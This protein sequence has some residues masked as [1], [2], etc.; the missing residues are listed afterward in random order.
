MSRWS[1][2]IFW[3]LL[4]AA[5]GGLLAHLVRHPEHLAWLG[6]NHYGMWF[7]D[8]HALLASNDALALGRDVYRFNPLDYFGRPHVYPHAWL[9]LGKLGLTRADGAALGFA[10]GTAFFVTAVA[11]LRPRTSGELVWALLVL[12]SPPVLLALDRG[13][14]DLVIFVLLAP[15]VPCLLSPRRGASYLAV[16]LIALAT[17]LKIYPAAAALVLLAGKTVREVRLRLAVMAAVFAV[18]ACDLVVDF[19]RYGGLVPRPDGLMTLGAANVF[20]AAGASDRLAGGLGLLAG[21]VLAASLWR[22]D[23]LRDWSIAPELRAAWVGFVLGAILLTGCFFAGLSFGYRWIFSL[24][25]LP[26]LWALHRDYA[27]PER[28]RLL[29]RVTSGLLFLGLW[30]DGMAG[31]VLMHYAK[32]LG[33]TVVTRWAERIFLLEQPVTWAFFACLLI[34]LLRFVGDGWR[35][36]SRREP[37]EA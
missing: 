20:L 27:T 3:W 12:C 4:V 7:L 10:L 34:F 5:S 33:P 23:W 35:T 16:L 17:A 14:N 21:G 22:L 9:L 28:V 19:G 30:I 24:W 29:A 2:R 32:A 18:M 13:N 15:V 36:V 1:P 26:F 6:V 31:T 11:G 25:L 8:T 37:A